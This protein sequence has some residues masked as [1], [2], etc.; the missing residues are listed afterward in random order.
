[1][2]VDTIR[3]FDPETQ[4]SVGDA[5]RVAIVAAREQLPELC[6]PTT[7]EE[8]R[9]KIDLGACNGVTIAKFQE[10]LAHLLTD[11]NP[12]TLA[13]YNGFLNRHTLANYLPSDAIVVMGP[14]QSVGGRSRGTGSQVRSAADKPAGTW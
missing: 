13:F 14:S 8:R 10:E 1:M 4:R 2:E 3:R 11:P 6:D 9:G 7:F 12:E 5:D